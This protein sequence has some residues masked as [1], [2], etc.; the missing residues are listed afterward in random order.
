M[1]NSDAAEFGGSGYFNT[2][3][4]QMAKK[5]EWDG[6]DQSIVM[7]LPPLSMLVFEYN[8]SSMA[9]PKDKTKATDK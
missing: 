9:A 5:V 2:V 8:D 3:E 4:S 7:N 6:K 1:L